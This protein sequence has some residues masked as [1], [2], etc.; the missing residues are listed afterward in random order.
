MAEH[1]AS[2][3]RSA[4]TGP[5]PLVRL[6]SMVIGGAPARFTSYSRP[7]RQLTNTS[8][9]VSL[10]APC[11]DCRQKELVRTAIG[12]RVTQGDRTLVRARRLLH[13]HRASAT[14]AAHFTTEPW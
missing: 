7:P 4:S 6:P 13:C 1:E 2:D 5:G 8:P 11:L 12:S 10:I 14:L 3:A 9:A